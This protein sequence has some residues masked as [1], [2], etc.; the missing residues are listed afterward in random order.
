M[1]GCSF[2]KRE[3]PHLPPLKIRNYEFLHSCNFF[4]LLIK[5]L[6]NNEGSRLLTSGLPGII[7]LL[8][9]VVIQHLNCLSWVI[10]TG[11]LPNRVTWLPAIFTL[12]S[13]NDRGDEWS[14]GGE[15][16]NQR[17][18]NSGSQSRPTDWGLQYRII[19]AVFLQLLTECS[20]CD[21][22]LC[23]IMYNDTSI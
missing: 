8:P 1:A 11:L 13:S 14:S 20:T 22:V 3:G 19:W 21:G 5:A 12:F 17:Q 6:F 18:V 10:K 2:F 9:T 4:K 15:S 7:V 16:A 23:V